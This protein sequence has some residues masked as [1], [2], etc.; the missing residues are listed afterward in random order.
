MMEPS[1]S[2][3]TTS[4][5][6]PP[7][8]IP[9]TKQ[10][11][12]PGDE[13]TQA[14]DD[15]IFVTADAEYSEHEDDPLLPPFEKEEK[16]WDGPQGQIRREYLIAYFARYQAKRELKDKLK[17]GKIMMKAKE[18]ALK[19]GKKWDEKEEK[20]Y[21]EKLLLE[22]IVKLKESESLLR[23]H[24]PQIEKAISMDKDCR[25]KANKDILFLDQSIRD[26]LKSLGYEVIICLRTVAFFNIPIKEDF[27]GEGFFIVSRLLSPGGK[28]RTCD[29]GEVLINEKL[30]NPLHNDYNQDELMMSFYSFDVIAELVTN[31]FQNEMNMR[32]STFTSKEATGYFSYRAYDYSS[33]RTSAIYGNIAVED[34][35]RAHNFAFS[36][37]RLKEEGEGKEETSQKSDCCPCLSQGCPDWECFKPCLEALGSC[38]TCSECDYEFTFSNDHAAKGVNAKLQCSLQKLV[39]REEKEKKRSHMHVD[40]VI[41]K[42]PHEV[43]MVIESVESY[44]HVKGIELVYRDHVANEIISGAVV[45]HPDMSMLEIMKLVSIVNLKAKSYR[46]KMYDKSDY[47][48]T[49]DGFRPY[50]GSNFKNRIQ[51]LLPKDDVDKDALNFFSWSLEI[52]VEPSKKYRATAC[53]N[54]LISFITMITSF[55]GSSDLKDSNSGGANALVAS[56][57]FVII[58]MLVKGYDANRKNPSTSKNLRLDLFG[59]FFFALMSMITGLLVTSGGSASNDSMSS[60]TN[61]DSSGSSDTA[62]D[63]AVIMIVLHIFTLGLSAL[64][65]VIDNATK[66]AKI[67]EEEKGL[68]GEDPWDLEAGEKTKIG[69]SSDGMTDMFMK[70][71]VE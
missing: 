19:N 66:N 39:L 58:N 15:P 18:N 54:V 5:M 16:E 25:E 4:P 20:E 3:T 53:I 51:G 59:S 10:A 52:N 33:R 11:G 64:V 71:R 24:G 38:C 50:R 45:F 48:E 26:M 7:D 9:P 22:G 27:T 65:L 14:Q 55:V 29:E 21:E 46:D 30:A 43:D 42:Q 68:N 62:A 1:N 31:S 47:R 69:S 28:G 36:Y 70:F 8:Y 41:S 56:G 44:S 34:V 63:S 2:G 6:A 40:A 23:L 37:A 49:R 61:D 32:E 57:I 60:N 67:E 13:N 35:I 17:D 12:E